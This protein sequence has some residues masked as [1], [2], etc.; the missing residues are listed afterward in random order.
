MEPSQIHEIHRK[1]SEMATRYQKLY[2]NL[3][4]VQLALTALIATLAL[5]L[6]LGVER[7]W[8]NATF[9]I[10]ALAFLLS[11]AV[12]SYS[13]WAKVER[14][15][16]ICRA[17]A[18][19]MKA[20]S[21]RYCTRAGEFQGDDGPAD[22]TLVY[23]LQQVEKEARNQ[24]A[25]QFPPATRSMEVH[26]D[27]KTLREQVWQQRREEYLAYR[28]DDQI[29]WYEHRTYLNSRNAKILSGTIVTTQVSGVAMAFYF[30]LLGFDLTPH[31]ALVVTIIA[32][33]LAWTQTRQYA[34]LVEPYR[35]ASTEL[36][37]I[38]DRVGR[39]GD[40]SEFTACIVESELAISREHSSWL[41]RHGI[42]MKPRATGERVN[43]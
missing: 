20:I 40:E 5:V 24:V 15:W 39:A 30:L 10:V 8:R 7:T 38:R 42:P 18:E 29:A 21:W 13:F 28:L 37:N 32:S 23:S 27:L 36:R 22:S 11:I 33:L 17:V 31:V 14:K 2:L 26:S 34:E 1:Y 9:G 41:A 12:Q 25:L 19:S 3:I 6:T 4:L 16:F 35:T 43:R